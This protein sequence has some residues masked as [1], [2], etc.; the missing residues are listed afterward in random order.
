MEELAA[1]GNVALNPEAAMQAEKAHLIWDNVEEAKLNL[2][3]ITIP[4][5]YLFGTEDPFF[6]DW[7][8][9]NIWAMMNTKNA[10]SVIL[11]G[12]RHLMELDTPERVAQEAFVFIEES[13][14]IY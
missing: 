2:E 13:K 11:G 9:N 7:K 10:R 1:L 8:D 5:G 12:E 3:N 14:N 4:V 6:T